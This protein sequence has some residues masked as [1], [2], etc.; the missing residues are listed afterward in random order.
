M[1]ISV[2]VLKFNQLLFLLYLLSLVSFFM[3]I[4]ESILKGF[5]YLFFFFMT[6]L[7]VLYPI[8]PTNFV[9]DKS[10]LKLWGLFLILISFSIIP[11]KIYWGQS[12][13]ASIISLLPFLMYSLY[14]L[15]LRMG[16]SKD[17]IVKCIEL[18]AVAHIVL[19]ILKFLFPAFPIGSIMEDNNRGD[20]VMMYGSFFNYFFFFKTLSDI[21]ESFTYRKGF[22][23]LLSFIAILLPMTRQR[24]LAV[25]F[26]GGWMITQ[27]VSIKK[28]FIVVFLAIFLLLGLSQ[29]NW[30]NDITQT[31]VS[32]LN[33]ENPYD[34]IREIGI[35]YYWTEFPE[36]GLNTYIGNGI[37]SYG[38]STYG[39]DAQD[40]AD[41]T[42][43]YLIDISLMAIYNYFGLITT[44]VLLWLIFSLLRKKGDVRFNYSKYLL[45]ML[46]L[47][48]ISS[49]TLITTGEFVFI[50]ICAYLLTPIRIKQDGCFSY[51]S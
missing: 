24:I 8:K 14:L 9:L 26:L 10:I 39:N 50:S 30:V 29:T 21:K 3:P 25:V 15:L 17:F 49:G 37:P 11:A 1:T 18:I 40:F 47:N 51:N 22:W 44:L 23:L 20:R 5:Q 34:H 6:I 43:I 12:Y 48:S 33:S 27:K 45:A 35:M 36:K 46:M 28:K 31:T 13:L 42:K 2:P 38:R 32:Q 19:S 16:I 7:A 4:G 41:N